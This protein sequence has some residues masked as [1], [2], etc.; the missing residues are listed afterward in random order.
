MGAGWAGSTPGPPQAPAS[1]SPSTARPASKPPRTCAKLRNA[2]G[3]ASGP[4]P[5]L[6]AR[7]LARLLARARGDTQSSPGYVQALRDDR[8]PVSQARPGH[9]F[10]DPLVR[11]TG[12]G[13][14]Q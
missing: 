8:P 2:T 5:V 13:I 6:E 3:R 7:R 4:G 14:L 12:P 11:L 10:P 9:Q 1:A